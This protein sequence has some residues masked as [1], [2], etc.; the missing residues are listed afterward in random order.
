M[1]VVAESQ[2]TSSL[3]SVM[4]WL[5]RN[6]PVGKLPIR[7]S[8]ND[9]AQTNVLQLSVEN[10]NDVVSTFAF[11]KKLKKKCSTKAVAQGFRNRQ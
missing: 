1:S 7:Q 5:Q 9:T 11:K 4:M 3:K 2:N 10:M 6:L 8:N